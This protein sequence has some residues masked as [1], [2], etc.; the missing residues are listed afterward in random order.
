MLEVKSMK[1]LDTIS[2]VIPI[3]FIVCSLVM[4]YTF[5][6]IDTI[7]H[8]TLYQYKLEYDTAWATPYWNLGG[9]LMAMGW[10]IVVVAGLFQA[11]LLIRKVPA[12]SSI[13]QVPEGR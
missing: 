10:T 9:I 13:T 4:L 1:V 7:V 5:T 2:R 11:Y 3:V 8:G 6:Q 12:P